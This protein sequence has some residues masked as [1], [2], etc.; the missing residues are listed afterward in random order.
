MEAE[1]QCAFL[2]SIELT[3]GTITDDSDIWLFGG[4]TVYKNFFN[5]SKYVMEFNVENIKHHFKLNREQLILL[6]L[7]VGSDYTTGIQGIGP[8]TALEILS[9]FPAGRSTEI[10]LSHSQLVS[11]LKE[12][13]AWFS[14]GKKGGV[15]RASL[16]S[17]L[18]NIDFSENFP[19]L[20]VVEAYLD[21]KV[22]TSNE[23]FSW[24]KPDIIAL[25]LFA[26]DKFGWSPKKTD[27]ILK[28]II[29]RMEESQS[30]KSIKDF[31]KT[32][33]KVHSTNVEEK[34]S[35]RVRTALDRFGKSEEELIAEEMLL[36]EK[37]EKKS[38]K[39]T[40]R[41]AENSSKAKT[42][43]KETEGVKMTD[44]VVEDKDF[45][46]EDGPKA[47]YSR[48]RAKGK[49]KEADE[50]IMTV[51]AVDEKD[52]SSED[53]PK[54]K[55]SRKRTDKN[56]DTSKPKEPIQDDTC[57]QDKI[58]SKKRPGRSKGQPINPNN[59][60]L[61]AGGNSSQKEPLSCDTSGETVDELTLY[62]NI[63]A[64][65]KIRTKRN[66]ELKGIIFIF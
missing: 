48:K 30:Q 34:L 24:A 6:A 21:P 57:R 9:A 13:K 32:R 44:G 64:E 54:T 8:V 45:S 47:K 3:D 25:T 56:E 17:K 35:K 59:N 41:R 22:E 5:Q 60:D 1:A 2:D 29:K 50:V 43:N 19:S 40:K 33:M 53:G 26:R 28:P 36:L 37:E 63:A 51:V 16:R 27:E 38:R 66:N 10:T 18:K 49:N 42:K 4:R 7:L 23:K 14:K 52:F 31:F 12:F 55:H 62:A 58:S 20:H 15:G 39:T 61:I 46:S 65:L 11:G